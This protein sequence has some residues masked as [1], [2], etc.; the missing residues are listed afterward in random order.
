MGIASVAISMDLF[1]VCEFY[2][3]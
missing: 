3:F 2:S 1:N